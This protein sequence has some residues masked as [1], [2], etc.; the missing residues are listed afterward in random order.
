M[1]NKMHGWTCPTCGTERSECDVGQGVPTPMFTGT[2]TDLVNA[3]LRGE[4][5]IDYEVLLAAKRLFKRGP[6][7]EAA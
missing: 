4:V 1:T 5:P 2:D 6:T 3:A 7:G